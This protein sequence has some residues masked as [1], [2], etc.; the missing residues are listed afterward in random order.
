ME[1]KSRVAS[2]SDRNPKSRTAPPKFELENMGQ[3]LHNSIH[4]QAKQVPGESRQ[5]AQ[6]E[7]DSIFIQAVSVN[8][9]FAAVQYV[10]ERQGA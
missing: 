3:S 4:N 10:Q 8:Q 2:G 1:G 9:V 7:A 5:Y 6:A